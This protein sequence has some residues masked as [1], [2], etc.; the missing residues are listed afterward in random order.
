MIKM[1][2]LVQVICDDCGDSIMLKSWQEA[3]KLDWAA[4][5][6]G[7]FQ[8]CPKC[9]KCYVDKLFAEAKLHEIAK[10]CPLVNKD[11]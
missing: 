5:I 6:D 10:K 7:A 1:I 4:P 11:E 2:E 3:S 8:R 9:K